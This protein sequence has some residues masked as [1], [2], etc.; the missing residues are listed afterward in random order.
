MCKLCVILIFY[1]A[2]ASNPLSLDDYDRDDDDD[3]S[4]VYVK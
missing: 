1:V 4:C 3:G 2:N